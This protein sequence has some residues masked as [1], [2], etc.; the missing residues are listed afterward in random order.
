MKRFL[1]CGLLAGAGALA[2]TTAYAGL[3]AAPESLLPPGFDDPAPAPSPAPRP[4]AAPRPVAPGGPAAPGSGSVPVIQP[5]PVGPAPDAEIAL[6]VELPSLEELEELDP[7]ELDEL[8]GL[9]PKY[10][11]PPAARRSMERI[12]IINSAEGGLP[13]GSLGRQ[14]ASIVRAALGGI[15]RPM[16]SRWGHIMLRRALASRLETPMGMEPAEFAGMRAAALNAIG[17]FEISR[18]L[19]QDVDTGNWGRPLADAAVEAYVATGDI[20]GACPLVRFQGGLRED[21]QWEMLRAICNAFSG[22]SARARSD[23]IRMRRDGD[24]A[25]IDVLL[26]QRY[27]GAAGRGRSAVNLEWDGVEELTPWRFGLATA[28]GAEIPASLLEDLGPDYLKVAARSAA[29]PL[30]QRLRGAELA[31][32]E[33][34]LSSSALIDLYSQFYAEDGTGGIFG[35][36]AVQLREAYVGVDPATRMAAIQSLWGEGSNPDYARLVLTAYAAARIPASDDLADQAGKLIAA[37]LAAGLDRD[38]MAWGNVVAEGS[39]G[40]ALLVLAQPTRSNPV[41][42]AAIDSFAGDDDSEGK[43]KSAF[44]IAGLAGLGRLETGTANEYSE[45]LGL[46]LQRTTRWSQLIDRSG[47]LQNQALVAYLAGVGMQGRNWGSMSP[48]HLFHI[49]RALNR[50]GMQAEARMIAAEAVARG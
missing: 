21:A 32:S 3:Q 50:A 38:A 47:E 15:Q 12:G 28:L 26:A 19:A 17:E 34:I 5:L 24:A 11:I 46:E 30:S 48:R 31:A 6:P 20:V 29:L 23:L 14:P 42:S 37:M 9:K 40:W 10:D 44:L 41:G 13:V 36:Q 22:E 2:L 16:V 25:A 45:A 49:V 27:A 18:A 1:V 39:E 43:R 4:T 35:P 8:L 33:G 7:D